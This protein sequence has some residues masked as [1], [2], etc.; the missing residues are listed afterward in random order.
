MKTRC[1]TDGQKVIPR[2]A[3]KSVSTSPKIQTISA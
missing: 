2:R 3:P 1:S